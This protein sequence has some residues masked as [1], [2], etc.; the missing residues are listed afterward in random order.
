[1]Q[2]RQPHLEFVHVRTGAQRGTN[3]LRIP[4]QNKIVQATGR[5]LLLTRRTH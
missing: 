5:R 4:L 3:E 2:R 1:M